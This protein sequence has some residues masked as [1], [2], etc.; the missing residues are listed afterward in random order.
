[1]LISNSIHVLFGSS[2]EALHENATVIFKPTYN[3]KD[4][5]CR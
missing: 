3:I 2:G 5:F 1:M 4:D